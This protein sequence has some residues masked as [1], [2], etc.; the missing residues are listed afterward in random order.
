MVC[1]I[2]NEP[3]ANVKNTRL[4]Q[5]LDGIHYTYRRYECRRCHNRF[6]TR[7]YLIDSRY[8]K[9]HLKR[10]ARIKSFLHDLKTLLN[11]EESL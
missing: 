1:P 7:E 10:T 9:E 5:D 8:E 3:R 11:S 6:T 4:R 2:C